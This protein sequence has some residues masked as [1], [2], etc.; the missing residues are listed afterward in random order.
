M[1]RRIGA[2]VK[3][4]NELA[5]YCRVLTQGPT[6]VHLNS[7]PLVF[8][9]FQADAVVP[10]LHRGEECWRRTG[11][12][13]GTSGA[14][15]SSKVRFAVY[16]SFPQALKAFFLRELGLPLFSTNK[17]RTACVTGAKHHRFWTNFPKI[18]GVCKFRAAE[19]VSI[20]IMFLAKRGRVRIQFF[21]IFSQ[22]SV[23]TDVIISCY[24]FV[25]ERERLRSPKHAT[26][27]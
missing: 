2:I 26:L 4:Q 9:F 23:F 25:C 3:G 14:Y 22:F 21:R 18:Q 10:S 12:R 19:F 16:R 13:H 20:V 1:K 7:L 5:Q 6:N 11:D 8:P 15:R 17:P 27:P 24:A